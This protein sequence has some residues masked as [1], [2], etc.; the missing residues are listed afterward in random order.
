VARRKPVV[1][2]GVKEAGEFGREIRLG[3]GEGWA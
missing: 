2:G 3:R 1:P